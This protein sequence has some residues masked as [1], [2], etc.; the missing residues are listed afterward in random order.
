MSGNQH[1]KTRLV[2][3]PVGQSGG[4]HQQHTSPPQQPIDQFRQPGVAI[5]DIVREQDHRGLSVIANSQSTEP[6]GA[7]VPSR[8]ASETPIHTLF[9]LLDTYFRW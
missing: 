3:Q 4:H 1:A 8:F 6:S 7:D 2:V 9:P 5:V